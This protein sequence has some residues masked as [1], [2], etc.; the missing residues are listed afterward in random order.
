MGNESIPGVVVLFRV[1]FA[2]LKVD[3]VE[4]GQEHILELLQGSIARHLV[5]LTVK[6]D[7]P[8]QAE[9]NLPP[10]VCLVLGYDPFQLVQVFLLPVGEEKVGHT[11]FQNEA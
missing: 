6:G 3:V 10:G 9:A 1:G 5:E 7:L 2:F 11:H 8:L 4:G